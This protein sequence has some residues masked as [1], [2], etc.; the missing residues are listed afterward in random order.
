MFHEDV[1]ARVPMRPVCMWRVALEPAAGLRSVRRK[2]VSGE[3]DTQSIVAALFFALSNGSLHLFDVVAV[4]R[5]NYE[6]LILPPAS[7][8]L[9]VR[10]SEQ[11]CNR[12]D[13]LETHTH[14][15]QGSVAQWQ[16]VRSPVM[17]SFMKMWYIE[18]ACVR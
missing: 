13:E 9:C 7:A 14:A 1:V 15:V 10:R 12:T 18:F 17:C 4:S 11:K 8:V 5:P 6:V 16:A 2:L 3:T